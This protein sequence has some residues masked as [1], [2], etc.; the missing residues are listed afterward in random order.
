M[1]VKLVDLESSEEDITDIQAEIAV[2][3][4]CASQ[5]VTRY[6]TSFLRGQKLWI[7]MEYLGGG[8]C[9]DLLKPGPIPEF[10]IAIIMREL[11]HGLTYLH[12]SSKL[13]R[14]VKAA[15][16][17]LSTAG[18]VK[19]ADFG[20]AA[21]LTSIKSLRN[22]FVGTPFWMAP[23]VIQQAGHDGKADIWSLGITAIELARGEPPRADVHPM[24]VLFLIPKESAPKL[25]G[26]G[27]SKDFKDFVA[28]C[29]VKDVDR[30]AGARDLLRHRFIR[31]AG[32]VERLRELV[33]RRVDWEEREA[34]DGGK[35]RRVKYYEETLR[36][37]PRV[38]A[39][40]GA[41]GGGGNEDDWVFDTVRPSAMPV[42]TAPP[43]PM[44]TVQQ[45]PDSSTM[46][47]RTKRRKTA[48]KMDID[49]AEDASAAM[50][51]L[52]LQL[53]T[54]QKKANETGE[55]MT[56]TMRRSSSAQKMP[57]SSP[58]VVRHQASTKKK[59]VSS[60]GGSV[61]KQPLG[62]NMS[63]G[64]SPSTVRQFRRVSQNGEKEKENPSEA[65]KSLQQHQQ[66]QQQSHLEH[67]EHPSY[68]HQQHAQQ[69]IASWDAAQM[70]PPSLP[71]SY[72]DSNQSLLPS[73]TRKPSPSPSKETL[74]GRRLYSKAI[75]LSCQEV[76][77]TTAGEEKR[78]AIAKL[79]EAFSDLELIDPEGLY[80]V[81][82]GVVERMGE[83]GKLSQLLPQGKGSG[84]RQQ[85]TEMERQQTATQPQSRLHSRSQSQSQSQNLSQA[86][87]RMRLIT[88]D[89][90]SDLSQPNSTMTNITNDTANNTPQRRET[91]NA[92]KLVLAQ[93]NPHL[94]S[95]RRRQSALG[96]MESSS[97]GGSREASRQGSFIG[98]DM[99]FP[100]TSNT[101]INTN[102]GAARE[103]AGL[104]NISPEDLELLKLMPG[105]SLL[106]E[107]AGVRLEMGP[108]GGLEHTRTLA[109]A[110][111]ERWCEGLR[112]RWP[113]A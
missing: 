6:K 101:N 15:N 20:V 14:D 56:S 49:V 69:A 57:P 27:W 54:P 23:E 60:G 41:G 98:G 13:H 9:Q 72:P 48:D 66:N 8:S 28:C 110:L 47:R 100:S 74:L 51:G 59:R 10:Y 29:L 52:S 89:M 88:P 21:Q 50:E 67:L 42:T 75:G 65:V 94:K 91:A 77:N 64:N 3:S 85:Q 99:P 12:A 43:A 80:H 35:G 92:A 1:A 68:Q 16:I 44:G 32:K 112:V 102:L 78:D 97:R 7:V 109:E 17:L 37:L 95:H 24:K 86:S 108:G 87:T 61:M 22:T 83:D 5:Y 90:V 81:M 38:D 2:L 33:Q 36:S 111:F 34:G 84:R 73:S 30:R 79:A 106:K 11:L 19:L 62:V 63:F 55:E 93:N 107:R 40:A 105:Q 31:G 58:S 18:S 76:L 39:D 113:N 53:H 104:E 4:S 46:M 71:S 26:G 96:V 82:R 45:M 25:E 103:R 70:P